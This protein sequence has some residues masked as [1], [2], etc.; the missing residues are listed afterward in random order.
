VSPPQA[1]VVHLRGESPLKYFDGAPTVR[2]TAGGRVVGE[3]HPA[4]DFDWRVPV[5]AEAV[6][7]GD[8]AI[9]IETDRVYRPGEVEGTGDVRQL[10]LRLFEIEVAPDTLIDR[11]SIGR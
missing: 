8:G 9:A 2:M 11:G 10:G 4:A 1:I 3:L 6:R 5:P 7:S